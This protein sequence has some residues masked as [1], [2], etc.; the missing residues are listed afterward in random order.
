MIWDPFGVKNTKSNPESKK[1]E[2]NLAL[3]FYQL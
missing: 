3:K 1:N 2:K